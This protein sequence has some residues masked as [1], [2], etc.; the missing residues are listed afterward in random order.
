[1]WIIKK[2]LLLS[3]QFHSRCG[4]RKHL[5]CTAC[6]F[7]ITNLNNSTVIL[8]VNNKTRTVISWL[9]GH[10]IL[11]HEMS[12]SATPWIMAS[13]ADITILGWHSRMVIQP[14]KDMTHDLLTQEVHSEISC[15][16]FGDTFRVVSW[17][18]THKMSSRIWNHHAIWHYIYLYAL[19]ISVLVDS[20]VYWL[21]ADLCMRESK[22]WF[23]S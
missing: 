17:P 18:P 1:M 13:M 2:K 7:M 19:S 14:G 4:R 16:C 6:W 15:R 22:H 23:S 12:W 20:F 21:I 11:K 8:W 9:I 3:E 10:S 5:R